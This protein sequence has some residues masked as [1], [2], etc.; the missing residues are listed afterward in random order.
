M[1]D[2]KSR[3]SR[4]ATS[5]SSESLMHLLHLCYGLI[6]HVNRIK[7][8]FS[9]VRLNRLYVL[10]LRFCFLHSMLTLN[11]ATSD[12]RLYS[13][14]LAGFPWYSEALALKPE[15]ILAHF[16]KL[17][18]FAVSYSLSLYA[19]YHWVQTINRHSYPPYTTSRMRYS[20]LSVIHTWRKFGDCWAWTSSQT[21]I[22]NGA[23]LLWLRMN[24]HWAYTIFKNSVLCCVHT[25]FLK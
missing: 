2:S 14:I 3:A 15:S 18:A 16:E 19:C 7:S 9:S 4:L 23:V 5:L 22:Q 12:R 11:I 21:W 1:I 25:D 10:C 13:T 20:I 24:R 17:P 6:F 8:M